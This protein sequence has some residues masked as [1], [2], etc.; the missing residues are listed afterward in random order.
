MSKNEEIQE[1]LKDGASLSQTTL[2]DLGKIDTFQDLDPATKADLVRYVERLSYVTTRIEILYKSG[3][4][5]KKDDIIR[6]LRSLKMLKSTEAS[7][8]LIKTLNVKER[9]RKNAETL[10]IKAVQ[11]AIK[12]ALKV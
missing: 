8:D 7:I 10:A 4:K 11:T 9:I 1:L 2:A 5:D 12:I 6:L 3:A